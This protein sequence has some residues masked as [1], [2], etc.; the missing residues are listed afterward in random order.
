MRCAMACAAGIWDC[1]SL[2]NATRILHG[3]IEHFGVT[4]FTLLALAALAAPVAVE[5]N[6]AA[7]G[8]ASG[9]NAERD[10]GSTRTATSSMT[11]P[12]SSAAFPTASAMRSRKNGVP[13]GQVRGARADG[14]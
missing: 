8:A 10:P 1:T 12:G 5:L 2:K 4:R 9:P 14:S 3:Q 7:D 13:P 11:T 6:R